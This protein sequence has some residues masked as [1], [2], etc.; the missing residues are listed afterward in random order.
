MQNICNN[1]QTITASIRQAEQKYA[2]PAG[3]VKLLAVSKYHPISALESAYQC[4]QRAFGENY[5]QEMQSK[6]EALLY[7]DLEWHFIG[8]IQSNKTKHIAATADWVHS[9]DR[10]KIAQR[11]SHQKP[12]QRAAISICIQ[13]NISAEASKSGVIPKDLFTLATQIQTLEGVKLR[14]LMAIP[15]PETDFNKQRAVFA[16]VRALYD[17]LN[18][19][20]F[21]LDTL[22]MGM[23]NDME[24]AIAEGANLVRIG[25]AIFGQRN[26]V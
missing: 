20:G 25:T 21:N 9:V 1:L 15:A 4:E 11:L 12:E 6:A 18:Q 14:G 16:Q 13:V 17:E 26:L 5:V 23:T 2:Y 19:Q 22:S 3:R 10:L 7:K 24:A 8:P